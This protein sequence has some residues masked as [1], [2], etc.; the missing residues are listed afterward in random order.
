MFNPANLD[1]PERRKTVS[2]YVKKKKKKKK[3]GMIEQRQAVHRRKATESE[4]EC[5]Y[6][7]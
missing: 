4:T 2:K 3:K 6:F 5:D 1:S 7:S